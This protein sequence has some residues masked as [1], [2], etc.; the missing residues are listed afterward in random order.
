M[1][2][3][4]VVPIDWQVSYRQRAFI[5]M[6]GGAHP[7]RRRCWILTSHDLPHGFKPSK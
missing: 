4:T 3:T 6:R 7:S 5:R 1:T 2:N